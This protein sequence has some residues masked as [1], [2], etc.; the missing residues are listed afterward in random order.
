MLLDRGP[1]GPPSS[2]YVH[3][4]FCRDRCTYCAFATLPDD[5][6]LHEHFVDALARE[7]RR[8]P[9]GHA[10]ETV[11][12]GGGTPSRLAPD[13][14]ERLLG[15]VCEA[16]SMPARAEVTLEVNPGDISLAALRAWNALGI[17]RLSVGTQTFRHDVLARLGRHDSTDDVLAA[18]DLVAAHWPHTWS[19]DLLVGW[20][21]QRR[22][23]VIA[24]V[25]QL[26]AFCPPHVSVYGLTIEEDTPLHRLQH[27]G[28]IVVAPS[29][30]RD[31]FDA[32]WSELLERGGLQRYEVSNFSRAGHR[33]RHNQV[34][35][36]NDSYVGL[37]PS[38]ASSVH[39]WR[40]T[41]Q[42]TLAAYGAACQGSRS[43]R[44][45]CERVTP[46]Q[47]LLETLAT[48]LRTRDGIPRAR[49]ERRF[50]PSWKAV[51]GDAL[52]RLCSIGLVRNDSDGI[53]L[54]PQE[55][56]RADSIVREL[57]SASVSDTSLIEY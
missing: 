25:N 6:S 46:V 37:G 35:W 32:T 10:L 31:A 16:T 39:P 26:L 45:A 41:N 5:P 13:V 50:G 22:S 48:G 44:A 42:R 38:A 29:T 51:L 54:P 2:V 11:Y 57:L 17:T 27:Q 19:A 15:V 52:P 1:D 40:W 21:G 55:L 18:L 8:A 43:A 3:V 47:R 14:L 56:P 36:R 4:P 7:A 24:D 53:S 23:D 34:Y 49:L 28:R 33:S 9:L 12:V 30:R 20:A